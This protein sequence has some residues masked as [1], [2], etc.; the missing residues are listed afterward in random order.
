MLAES[1]SMNWSRGGGKEEKEKRRGDEERR[2]EGFRIL[3]M[4]N[5]SRHIALYP[6][7]VVRP[8]LLVRGVSCSFGFQ[9]K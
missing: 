5:I 3:L 8:V 9:V 7:T 4:Y 2:Y 1:P 6:W